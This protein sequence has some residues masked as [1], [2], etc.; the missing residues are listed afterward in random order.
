MKLIELLLKVI[1]TIIVGLISGIFD[2][3]SK[4]PENKLK[5]KGRRSTDNGLSRRTLYQCFESSDL[6]FTSRN[7]DIIKGGILFLE[8]L[9]PRVTENRRSMGDQKFSILIAETYDRYKEDYYDRIFYDFQIVILN[10]S[11]QYR[12]DFYANS[13]LAAFRR[14]MENQELAASKLK[15]ERGRE[16][17]RLKAKETALSF[18]SVLNECAPQASNYQEVE[19]EMKKFY[20]AAPLLENK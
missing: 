17:R 14:Y 12:Q 5:L 10:G 9:L 18:L 1:I 2:L 4:K 11:Q 13:I 7:S 15:T 6:I 3:L 19:K 8:E 20:N 16:N